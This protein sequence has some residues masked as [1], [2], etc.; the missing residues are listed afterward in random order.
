M[1]RFSI[2]RYLPRSLYGR[3][4]LILLV[5]IVTIQLVVS[6]AFIQRLY[7]DVTAQMT[8]NISV[9]L[10]LLL[11]IVESAGNVE[12]A[13]T[14]LVQTANALDI[15]VTFPGADVQERRRF[16]DLS[17]RAIRETL[18]QQFE[19][20]RAVDLVSL[21]K[22]VQASLETSKGVL[23]VAFS[24]RRVAVSNPHQLLVLMLFTAVLM[25]VISYLFLRNQL[26]PIR[27]LARAAEAFGKGRNEPYYPGGALEVRS[28]G[29]AF[30]NMRARIERQIEQRTLMLS[31]VSHDLRTPLTRLKLGLSMQPDTEEIKDLIGDVD[32]MERL[33]EA[34]LDFAKADAQEE[35]ERADPIALVKDLVANAQRSGK[36]VELA[37][38]IPDAVDMKLR[39]LSVRRAVENLINNAVRYGT[40]AQVEIAV[41]E[42][43]LRIS[44]EDNGPGIPEAR[45]E[46]AVKAFSRLDASR[47]QNAGSGVGLGL[48]IAADVARSHGG[49]LRLGDSDHLGGLK[50]ELVLPR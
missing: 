3:A 16:T 12:E 6:F 1:A 47:N 46:Q 41:L 33:I 49:T 43:A 10:Q 8:Q 5:P 4:A 32:E 30:L 19:T 7:E 20:L 38:E 50:A 15:D 40:V 23:E 9:E 35:L 31:G 48:A 24:R 14:K 44:V 22:T 2:K 26:R 18:D 25:T 17:G 37:G 29:A 21:D 36:S 45:R 11:D 42:T 34:F 27:R 39:P 28:A 13:A